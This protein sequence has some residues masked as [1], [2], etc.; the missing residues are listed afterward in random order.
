[1]DQAS[2]FGGKITGRAP[3]AS[4]HQAWTPRSRMDALA[5]FC[6]AQ[7]RPVRRARLADRLAAQGHGQTQFHREAPRCRLAVQGQRF[8]PQDQQCRAWR[9]RGGVQRHGELRAA[10]QRQRRLARG[11]GSDRAGQAVRGAY[12]AGDEGRARPVVHLNR[13][14]ELLDPPAA[15]HR[16]PVGH[17][18]RL[19]LVV[20]DQ[21]G[22][23]AEAPLQPLDLDLHVEAEGAVQRGEGLV[24]QQD[25]RLR[26]QRPCQGHA[27]LLP[28]GKLPRP[29]VPQRRELHHFQQLRHARGNAGARLAAGAGPVCDVVRHRHVREKGVVLEHD[30][31]APAVGRQ[32]VHRGAVDQH[33]PRRWP[34]EA[35][36]APQQGGLPAAG[37]AEQRQH[38]ARPGGQAH[39]VQRGEGAVAHCQAQHVQRVALRRGRVGGTLRQAVLTS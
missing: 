28:P 22:G 3:G 8:R 29:P 15:H 35:R 37:R 34:D 18:H 14:A 11:G 21:D 27:L 5:R 25:G 32:H 26:R 36:D 9:R 23:E 19:V 20:R 6:Q 39:R 30:A 33:L 24:Q 38:L 17:A 2:S 1:M 31:D 16:D 7:R 10:G 13:R 4:P 12:E